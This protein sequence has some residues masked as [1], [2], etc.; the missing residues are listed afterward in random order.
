LAALRAQG[1]LV[2]NIANFVAMDLVANALLAVGASPA[3][4]HAQEESAEFAAIA[5]A[6]TV[7]LGTMEPHW[8]DSAEAAAQ[9]AVAAG[10]PWVLDPVAV[11]A[12]AFR[13]ANAERLMACRP[14]VVRGNA[15]EIMTLA[16]IE[17]A[18]GKG[19]DSSVGAEAAAE[20]AHALARRSG[21]V[22]V[23]T[24]ALDL[25]TDGRRALTCANGDAMLTRVTAAGCALTAVTGACL[26][27][28]PDPLLAA[29]H[30]L[31]LYGVAGERA[32]A[33][34]RGPGSLRVALLD[35][36]YRLEPNTLDAAARLGGEAP[37]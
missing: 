6:L 33:Q 12:T 9:A 14:T 21:A 32:A 20:A 15:S 37:A 26:A 35:E 22:V 3:M 30:A 23:V 25:A 29:A 8:V 13:R 19:V 7:N 18:G 17:G 36:L 16:G 1:P 4:V 27:V 28:E 5:S 2:Q 34:A 11:G 10:R 24:G 31:A